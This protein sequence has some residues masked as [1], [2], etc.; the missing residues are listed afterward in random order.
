MKEDIVKEMISRLMEEHDFSMQEAFDAVYNSLLFEKLN[1]PKTGLYFQSPGYVYSYLK[2]E[3][4]KV[5]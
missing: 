1:N 5:E 4:F 3:L 2:D